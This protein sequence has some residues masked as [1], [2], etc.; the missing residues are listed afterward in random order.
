MEIYVVQQGDTIHTV[1][2]KFNI[3]VDKLVYDNGLVYP[4]NLVIGQAIIIAY[5]KQT[6][7]VHEGETLQSIA[8]TYG[9]SEMQILRNNSFISDRGTLIL[10]ETLVI[11]YNT[12]MSIS[13]NGFIYP[14]V[15][16]ETLLKILPNLTY[17]TIFN[18]TISER[19]EV[20]EYYD[21]SSVVNTAKEYGVIP[22]LLAST[23]SPQ[24]EPNIKI[25]YDILLSEE[26]QD[27]S[28]NQFVDIM[29]QKGYLGMN[30]VLNF[31]DK[32][33]QSL[34]LN[35][36]RR[37]SEH[38][39]QEG[40]MFFIT[41][42]YA[43]QESNGSISIE[44]I[45]YSKFSPYV[46][47]LIFIKFVWSTNLGPPSPV[48]NIENIR[49]VIDYATSL[50]SSDKIVVG[51]PVIGY[52]WQLPYVPNWSNVSSMSIDS[53][54]YLAKE[55]GVIIQFDEVSKTPYFYYN[56]IYFGA[57]VEHIVW[58]IDVRSIEELSDVILEYALNG[59]GIWNTMIYY[60]QVWTTM[61]AR[62][63]TVKLI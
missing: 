12:I 21:D 5:P 35:F 16:K 41:N 17:L 36:V 34:Y 59:S 62:F 9:V 61:N 26:Y 14:Y 7:I 57:P 27:R 49:A 42:N 44:D 3:A 52:D 38:L 43:T 55:T 56:Q 4:Y 29:K 53:A 2:E 39:Q 33:N 22:L 58:F 25:A 18:Y 31:L 60:P 51:N 63:D 24:G 10:G 54:L 30:I 28:I 19:G 40:L 23:L 45:D 47:G 11:S 20:K 48:S 13:T 6:H 15:R 50:V 46:N 37:I 32:S 1:A 8:N